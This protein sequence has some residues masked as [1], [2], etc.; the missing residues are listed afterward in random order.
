MPGT[1]SLGITT[2][3]LHGFGLGAIQILA[4]LIE[5]SEAHRSW[6]LATFLQRLEDYCAW[7]SFFLRWAEALAHLPLDT[8]SQEDLARYRK[9]LAAIEAQVPEEM[10][11]E[12]E[13][14]LPQYPPAW[15]AFY[16]EWSWLMH[17]ATDDSGS[18]DKSRFVSEDQI[19]GYFLAMQADLSKVTQDLRDATRYLHNLTDE[20][21]EGAKAVAAAEK[22]VAAL[23][24]AEAA[25]SPPQR[26]PLLA[27][28]MIDLPKLKS[29]HAKLSQPLVPQA[30][31]ALTSIRELQASLHKAL[32]VDRIVTMFNNNPALDLMVLHEM[33]LGQEVL[34]A[35]LEKHGL[36]LAQGPLLVSAGKRRHNEYY[37]IVF[38]KDARIEHIQSLAYTGAKEPSSEDPVRWNKKGKS[39]RPIVVYDLKVDGKDVRVGIVHTTP[40]GQEFE[41]KQVFDEIE[42]QLKQLADWSK[43]EQIPLVIGGDYY[44]TAEAVVLKW[45][46]LSRE[47][48]QRIRRYLI[49]DYLW[50]W[51]ALHVDERGWLNEL[52]D[53]YRGLEG[54]RATLSQAA[55]K[56]ELKPWLHRMFLWL[57]MVQNPRKLSHDAL[58]D[59]L[60]AVLSQETPT[61]TAIEKLLPPRIGA[62]DLLRNPLGLTVEAR[63]KAMGYN[64]HQAISGTN[65]KTKNVDAW[66]DGQI[67]DFFASVA[68]EGSKVIQIGI[69]NHN[70][71][72]VA[73]DQEDLA[74]TRYGMLASDH[75][76]VFARLEL[77]APEKPD[78]DEQAQAPEDGSDDDE[79]R[80]RDRKRQK[81]ADDDDEQEDGQPSD[82]QHQ[83]GEAGKNSGKEST[84]KRRKGSP[85]D[86]L[87]LGD[88]AGEE[89]DVKMDGGSL[90]SAATSGDLPPDQAAQRASSSTSSRPDGPPRGSTRV[91]KRARVTSGEATH[92]KE[93]V[94]SSARKTLHQPRRPGGKK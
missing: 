73:V 33:N 38:R 6:D 64:V 34:A 71:E 69:V 62:L 45:R 49:E 50:R 13:R 74:I 17:P 80:R 55:F 40:E 79:A 43:K 1:V 88:D 27:A 18:L 86:S 11:Q 70:G 25:A 85:D 52:I 15:A 68:H 20:I 23:A 47:Q 16:G 56:K 44:L 92:R 8:L 22:I 7:R 93:T 19:R 57:D 67:A 61:A 37:P 2:W 77:K 36:V 51:S 10:R 48:Q 21:Q 30:N 31:K 78:E 65:W 39:F 76:A 63:L 29:F 94:S 42:V 91:P 41:R 83:G 32:V 12:A 9:H 84:H 58:M 3:N 4:K 26:S 53:D 59:A 72:P 46:D 60:E 66:A 54:R 14:R 87:I 5:V 28:L 75:L 89:D 81:E 24:R 35:E 82:G 90:D